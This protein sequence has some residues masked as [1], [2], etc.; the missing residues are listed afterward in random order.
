MAPTD[1]TV[2]MTFGEVSRLAES[3]CLPRA[4]TVSVLAERYRHQ[5]DA[6]QAPHAP[7]DA[8]LLPSSH[9]RRPIRERLFG[10]AARR[11]F[12][13]VAVF[14]F[15]SLILSAPASADDGLYGGGSS[16]STVASVP[17][18]SAASAEQTRNPSND[19]LPFTGG[20]AAG[21]AAIGLASV[22]GGAA[23]VR[24]ARRGAHAA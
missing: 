16:G 10:R 11:V 2:S 18:G 21:L 9:A 22:G 12:L 17:P 23:L 19:S 24:R 6:L 3:C 5:H 7:R 15:G 1:R 14:F 8:R 20:D 4:G 13:G